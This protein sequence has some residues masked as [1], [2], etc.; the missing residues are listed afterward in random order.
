ML[1][2]ILLTG[3]LVLTMILGAPPAQADEDAPNTQTAG[4]IQ[5]AM[6]LGPTLGRPAFVPAG[7]ELVISAQFPAADQSVSMTLSNPKAGDQRF[8]LVVPPDA[9]KQL[10][11]GQPVTVRV[12]ADVPAYTY[13]LEIH[14]G[15][16]QVVGRHCVAVGSLPERIRLVHLSNMNVGDVGA[17]DF[18]WGLIEE[19]NLVAP[20]LIVATGDLLDVTHP[21]IDSGWR[22][23]IEYFAQFDAPVLIACGDHDD[24]ESYS[25]YVAPSPVG[26]INLGDYRMVVLYDTA[27]NPIGH[28]VD[29][30]RWFEELLASPNEQRI[31]L[32]ASHDESPNLLKYWQQQGNL[33]SMVQGTRL[34]LWF[35][36]GHR[37]W[38][39]IEYKNLIESTA[40]M[41]YLRTHQSSTA[42]CDGATGVSH[43]RVVDLIDGRANI[44]GGG[45]RGP[46]AESI[47]AG[48]LRVY[49]DGPNDGTQ[50]SM[51]FTVV[52]NL[53]F[54]INDLSVRVLLK[55]NPDRQ[56]WYA[57]ATLTQVTDLGDVWDCRVRVDLPDKGALHAVV[58][59]SATPMMPAIDVNIEAPRQLVLQ[60]HQDAEGL[61]YLAAQSTLALIHLHNLGSSATNVTPLVRLDGQ[62]LPY[63]ILDEPGPAATAY[64]LRLAPGRTLTLQV[65]LSAIRVAP[66]Y[67][68][69][70]VYLKGPVAWRPE[71]LPLE[72]TIEP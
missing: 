55:R 37:D 36:G 72:V 22:R 60:R 31:T 10:S 47:A 4:G 45:E 41:C 34:G 49:Y 67:R 48:H 16:S 63:L 64:R 65:E 40:P 29:Q 24:L 18:D 43:Y 56:P 17:P 42:T 66:G 3:S 26:F 39:G 38:D 46:L 9:G 11:T 57:G 15:T 14:A 54:R 2:A 62:T 61:S 19:I 35:C 70:Q 59:T 13:D 20:T 68:E 32:V 1:K 21:D 51:S 6:L 30:V 28:D 44:V 27:R 53:P 7:G 69:L 33:A 52:N 8:P 12:P 58:G 50:R 5:K 71:C 23:A 25:R